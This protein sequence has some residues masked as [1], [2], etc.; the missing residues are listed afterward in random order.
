LNVKV[1]EVRDANT[2]LPVVAIR[3]KPQN[4]S[5]LY[6]LSRL[7]YG[8][9]EE[10]QSGW[11]LLARL[12]ASGPLHY[13]HSNWGDDRTMMEAHKYIQENWAKLNSGAVV[14]VEYVIGDTHAPKQSERLDK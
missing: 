9:T 11:V 2:F 14:D 6:L 3:T 7:G 5:E 13:H 1:F 10:K 8:Y 12:D 4:E